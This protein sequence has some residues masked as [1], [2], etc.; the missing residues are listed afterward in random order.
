MDIKLK[1]YVGCTDEFLLVQIQ[2]LISRLNHCRS[3]IKSP[4][5][6]SKPITSHQFS[7]R[8]RQNSRDFNHNSKRR[9][10]Q[11]YLSRGSIQLT[12]Q[13]RSSSLEI[14]LLLYYQNVFSKLYDQYHNT[15]MVQHEIEK[16][17]NILVLKQ[18]FLDCCV[19]E[20]GFFL[21][22]INP[23]KSKTWVTAD[24]LILALLAVQNKGSNGIINNRLI[25]KS[26]GQTSVQQSICK[27]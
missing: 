13:S 17:C 10:T 18:F 2:T 14:E 27:S 3:S 7:Y 4:P 22:L 6:V 26:E 24:D 20:S 16:S 5:K 12:P 23:I 21:G 11:I 19:C 15:S 1:S 25:K 8:Y 9:N